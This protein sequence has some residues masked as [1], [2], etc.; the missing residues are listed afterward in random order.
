M[1]KKMRRLVSF[2]MAVF[3]MLSLL[4]T[5]AL[6][7][8][9]A[10]QTGTEENVAY[11]SPDMEQVLG[12][13]KIE[14]RVTRK[15][16]YAE[17]DNGY[18]T[19]VEEAIALLRER[20]VARG[21]YI[22]LPLRVS[23]AEVSGETEME[24]LI[25]GIFVLATA[26]TGVADEGDYLLWQIKDLAYSA[27]YSE[28]D[29]YYYLDITYDVHYYTSSNAERN[30]ASQAESVLAGFG[31]TEETDDYTKIFSI[32]TFICD[33]VSYDY[34]NLENESYTEKFTA[35]AALRDG[36]AVCQGYALLLYYMLLSVGIDCRIIA[37]YDA[38]TGGGHAWN[39][40]QLDGVY[41][42]L[43]STWDAGY[44]DYGYFLKSP[45]AFT[46]HIRDTAYD[47]ID[48][49][50]LYPMA[51]ED[52]AL[53]IPMID[54]G[55]CGENA[56]YT[57]YADGY[58]EITGTGALR[59]WDNEQAPW[60]AYSSY[61][62]YVF[63]D[64]GIT[65]VGDRTFSNIPF[66]L[67]VVLPKGL[68][69]IGSSAFY[70]S[71]RLE[72]VSLPS[73]LKLVEIEA[74]SACRNLKNVLITDLVAWCG[75]D[76]SSIGANPLAYGADLY[77]NEEKVTE[78]II[79]NSITQIKPY[80]FCG[81]SFAS[82]TFHSGVKEVGADAFYNCTKLT[83]VHI[84]DL[85]AWCSID[86]NKFTSAWG[87]ANPLT[88]GAGLYLNGSLVT[89]LVIPDGVTSIGSS[90]F[91]GSAITSVTIPASVT[92]IGASAFGG[93]EQLKG[94]YIADLPAWCKINFADI[95]ANPLYNK[96]AVYLNGQQITELVI[97]TS[98]ASIEPYAFAGADIASVMV[99]NPSAKIGAKAFAYSSLTSLALSEGV[100]EL[101]EYAFAYSA[102]K[103]LSLPTSLT[104]IA[105]Y[106]FYETALTSLVLPEG[107]T[108]VG[109][110]AF[111]RCLALAEI[112][113]PATLRKVGERAFDRFYSAGY[114]IRNVYITDLTAWCKMEL[115]ESHLMASP[116]GNEAYLYLNGEKI[117]DLVIPEGIEALGP[118]VFA[119]CL[120]EMT[121]TLPE[122][123]TRI[124]DEAF[125]WLNCKTLYIPESVSYIGDRAFDGAEL[126][127]IIFKGDAPDFSYVSFYSITTTAYYPAGNP[128]WT[129]E[130]RQNYGGNI[131]WVAACAV[132]SF[133]NGVCTVCGEK[134]PNFKP[135]GL[136][137]DADGS[138]VVD[139][140]DA[141]LVLQYHTGVITNEALALGQ[142]DVD[143]SGAV[144]YV[145]AM[146]ILQYH[147]GVISGF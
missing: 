5:S 67:V 7:K 86:F 14:G 61:V 42:N 81:G 72:T 28:G 12:E 43:D 34:E 18:Y 125:A 27:I 47:S 76:F 51:Q 3:L 50:T 87:I 127:Q 136:L 62:R 55:S 6:A 121:V 133:A 44:Y 100:T 15:P 96:A 129:E 134:D 39:I 106:A 60:K 9:T 92:E 21:T 31:F 108:E 132:H 112:T 74:F 13:G 53:T 71:G 91:Y 35:E 98:V 105:P 141:M 143:S 54:S 95:E 99:A 110:E 36:K 58:M 97:D 40:V 101:G 88:L 114:K 64:E 128:T 68:E 33:T 131:T 45:A 119:R 57:I 16:V 109:E 113:V 90:A 1:K 118:G 46:D 11:F 66:L 49:H 140:V 70:N 26:H 137:G 38:V 117:T 145:D 116:I 75:I 107:V 142:C 24:A 56:Q 123:L 135:D 79:P 144:D 32:Y 63:A 122:S 147:T 77:L 83:Q 80:A 103:T 25:A 59:D 29:G 2:T 78:L 52:Y 139:Y 65:R 19:D 111:N 17:K 85:A 23:K 124:E 130:V 73:T 69:S 82:V 89:E 93:C 120:N 20:M 37:G 94:V 84:S 22:K 4:P 10:E 104:V 41:Y 30:F 126:E 146:R 102:L 48:F 115:G 8:E 138:G